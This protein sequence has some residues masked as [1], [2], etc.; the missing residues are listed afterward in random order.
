[1]FACGQY[2]RLRRVHMAENGKTHRLLS[3]KEAAIYLETIGCPR[4]SVRT[5][6]KWAANKNAGNGPPFTKMRSVVGYAKADLDQW[7]WREA[8]RIA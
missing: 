3:R 2:V 1:M 7:A 4:I 8:V 6:E 5:L